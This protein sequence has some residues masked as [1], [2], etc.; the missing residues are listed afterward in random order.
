MQILQKPR[1]IRP[2]VSSSLLEQL[3]NSAKE[4]KEHGVVPKQILP[5]HSK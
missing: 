3:A 2:F 4:A 5:F 1:P